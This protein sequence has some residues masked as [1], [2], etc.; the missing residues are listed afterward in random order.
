MFIKAIG[1]LYVTSMEKWFSTMDR[2]ICP[3]YFPTN[4]TL[5]EVASI[6]NRKKTLYETTKLKVKRYKP[7]GIAFFNSFIVTNW[8]LFV[9]K[10]LVLVKALTPI[11]ISNTSL[12]KVFDYYQ[13]QLL[14]YSQVMFESLDN[15]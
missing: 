10:L 15:A 2:H 13:Q 9:S 3:I 8:R 1:K 5:F 4:V 11:R 7:P 6:S 14:I 12:M